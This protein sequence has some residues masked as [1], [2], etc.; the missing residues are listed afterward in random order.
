MLDLSKA[1]GVLLAFV[2]AEQ[3][4]VSVYSWQFDCVVLLQVDVAQ[5]CD[6]SLLWQHGCVFIFQ[7]VKCGNRNDSN[8]FPMMLCIRWLCWSKSEGQR[9]L[10]L[11]SAE[12][13]V[14]IPLVK[15][16]IRVCYKN[17][18]DTSVIR[19]ESDNVTYVSGESMTQLWSELTL[20]T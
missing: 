4:W 6:P 18:Y 2:A 20:T 1:F 5:M 13:F 14:H 16:V 19:V 9:L 10:G 7:M 3:M 8:N 11:L 15:C 17:L 12:V